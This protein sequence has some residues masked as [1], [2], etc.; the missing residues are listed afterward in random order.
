M[1]EGDILMDR[2]DIV[3][4]IN[5]GN[6]C[7]FRC[8]YCYE[9]ILEERTGFMSEEV[10][11][12]II[13]VFDDMLEKCS[14]RITVCFWGGEPTLNPDIMF[15]FLEYYKDNSRISFLLYTNGS[16]LHELAE[17]LEQYKKNLTIQVSYDFEP[18][19]SMNRAGKRNTELVR[20]NII[21]IDK[22][23]F[24]Y[25]IK[26]TL[27]LHDMETHLFDTYIDYLKLK[28]ELT[29]KNLP[30]LI[31]PDVRGWENQIVNLPAVEQELKRCI[32][33][34]LKN[35]MKTTGFKWFDE[36]GK[37]LCTTPKHGCLIDY[38]G[39]FYP[40]HGCSYMDDDSKK[41]FAYMNLENYSFEKFSDYCDK[42]DLT[43][44]DE[45]KNCEVCLCFKCNADNAISTTKD[46]SGWNTKNSDIQCKLY[47]IISKYIYAYRKLKK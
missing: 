23:G 38:D 28:E 25:W 20:N 29:Q 2:S 37:A 27:F 7:N 46:M 6:T 43:E 22:M 42:F 17:K 10:C 41:N 8:K 3:I 5:L 32:K 21:L 11:D 26:S 16:K 47:H 14:N 44:P 40:C 35:N 36:Y 9:G 34:F 30:L 13:K 19:N 4:D 33:F 1:L 31:T 12:S 24:N 15:K 45:C 18:C 39:T